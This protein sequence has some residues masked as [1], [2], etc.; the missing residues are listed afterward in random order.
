LPDLWAKIV[1][2]SAA[3]NRIENNLDCESS[4]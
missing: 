3:L 4:A 1:N 2:Y